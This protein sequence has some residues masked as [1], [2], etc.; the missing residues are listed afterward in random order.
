MQLFPKFRYFNIQLDLV[1]FDSFVK[2]AAFMQN[3]G[4]FPF[5]KER[6]IW[7]LNTLAKNA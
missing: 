3:I 4:F 5:M 1:I 6:V 2:F 7:R